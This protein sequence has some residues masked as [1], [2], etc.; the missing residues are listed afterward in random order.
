MCSR[1]YA[2]AEGR[3][4]IIGPRLLVTELVARE[5]NQSKTLVL[6]FGVQFLQAYQ[7]RAVCQQMITVAAQC[8]S[9]LKAGESGDKPLF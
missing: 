4:V 5:T 9:E 3:D 1:Y 7:R 2:L 6:V 8:I